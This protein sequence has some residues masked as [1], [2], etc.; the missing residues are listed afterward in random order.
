MKQKINFQKKNKKR[1]T[2]SEKLFLLAILLITSIIILNIST[3]ATQH[4][5]TSKSTTQ[6]STF[7]SQIQKITQ[8][9]SLNTNL[10]TGAFIGTQD[11]G[12]QSIGPTDDLNSFLDTFT[13]GI[14]TSFYGNVTSV[15][16]ISYNN[17]NILVNGSVTTFASAEIV[18]YQ[19][20]SL[21]TFNASVTINLSNT[22]PSM[23]GNAIAQASLLTLNNS[24]T[25]QGTSEC[26]VAVNT[27]GIYTLVAKASFNS[28]NST[29]LT[30]SGT[31]TGFGTL[32][33][34]F[35]NSTNQI[36]CSFGGS[37][38]V[39]A[40]TQIGEE[41]GIGLSGTLGSEALSPPTG[42]INLTFDNFNY[43]RTLNEPLCGTYSTSVTLKNHVSASGTCFT[44]TSSNLFLDCKGF[45][46]TFGNATG[47]AYGVNLDTNS[48]RIN[49]T[50]KNC[51]IND[52]VGGTGDIGIRYYQSHDNG[53]IWNNTI[54]SPSD[55]AAITIYYSNNTN[56][57]NNIITT[58][59]SSTGLDIEYSQ[60]TII[61]NNFINTSTSSNGIFILTGNATIDGNTINTSGSGEAISLS[62]TLN[63]TI[64]QNNIIHTLGNGGDGIDLATSIS[65]L[66]QTNMVTCG[67]GPVSTCLS[68]SSSNSSI[69]RDNN[70]TY[71]GSAGVGVGISV[72]SEKNYFI[73]N[74]ITS[75]SLGEISD[76][77]AS[78]YLNYV[79]YNNSF[80]EIKWLDN[81]TGS[82]PRNL[83]MSLNRT[84]GFGSNIFI[85]NNTIA[86]NKSAWAFGAIS[87]LANLTLYGINLSSVNSINKVENFTTDAVQ[88]QAAGPNCINLGCNNI[89]YIGNTLKFNTSNF[90]SFAANYSTFGGA[91]SS[92]G[93]LSTT[94]T[95]VSSV[96]STSTCF[97]I[98]ASNIILDCSG[99]TITYSTAGTLGYGINNSGY[100]NITIQNCRI[101]EGNIST[102]S[103]YGIYFQKNTT[104]DSVPQ[105]GTI[106]N[107]TLITSGASSNAIELDD[108]N[109]TNVS[110]NLINTTG[111]SAHG[112]FN[113]RGSNVSIMYNKIIVFNSSADNI[114]LATSPNSFLSSNNLTSYGTSSSTIDVREASGTTFTS[115]NLT[116]FGETATVFNFNS[117]FVSNNVTIISNE[118]RGNGSVTYLLLLQ[119]VNNSLV[120]NNQLSESTSGIGIYFDTST[121]NTLVNNNISVP[122]GIGGTW[123]IRDD[124]ANDGFFNYLI[125][126][127]SFGEIKWIDNGTGSFG[128]NLDVQIDR[129]ISSTS[130]I[131]IGNNTIAVNASAFQIG[132]INSTANLTLFSVGLSSIGQIQKVVNFTT[133]STEI[134]SAGINCTPS[135]GCSIISYTGGTLKFNTSSFSSFAGNLTAV[136][137]IPPLFNPLPTNQTSEFGDFFSYDF[138]ATDDVAISTYGIN[139][140]SLF[141]INSTGGLV[142]ISALSTP[143]NYQFNI[144][145][146]DTSNN[147][148]NTFFKIT[149]QDTIAPSFIPLIANQTLEVGNSFSYDINATDAL[150][151]NYSTNY[152][153]LFIF[154]STGGLTNT[155]SITTLGRFIFNI[156]I[157]DTS[158]NRNG[159]FFMITMQDTIAP[160]FIPLVT[161]QTIEYATQFTYDINATDILFANY[162]INDTQFSINNTGGIVNTTHLSIGGYILNISIND[163][164]N[165]R[166]STFFKITIQ[167]TTIP[168]ISNISNLTFDNT[169]NLIA[170]YNASD[171]VNISTW[172]TNDTSHFTINTT[173]YF[174]NTTILTLATYWINISVNDTSNNK[175]GLIIFVNVTA[176]VISS[177]N[178]G[179]GN[180][181]NN[182][183][184]SSSSSSETSTTTSPSAPATNPTQTA[185][186]PQSETPQ[187]T[188]SLSIDTGSSSGKSSEN[189][190]ESATSKT[191]QLTGV[192]AAENTQNNQNSPFATGFALFQNATSIAT[193]YS[194][195]SLSLFAFIFLLS[196][197]VYTF[198]TIRKIPFR[199]VPTMIEKPLPKTFIEKPTQKILT[200][201]T[202]QP[203]PY[204]TELQSI[205]QEI[206][207]YGIQIKPTSPPH[208]HKTFLDRFKPSTY[209]TYKS[210]I[211]ETPA[212]KS[213][214]DKQLQKLE[215]EIANLERPIPTTNLKT[216]PTS[217]LK[218]QSTRELLER[219]N[220]TF[221]QA[222]TTPTQNS[223]ITN[224]KNKSNRYSERYHKELEKIEQEIT[225]LRQT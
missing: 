125:Y 141:S 99:Y 50:V 105:K 70:I 62:S 130:N 39:N 151:A 185:D 133:N 164:S 22:S 162:S 161:N 119:R 148:N 188:T 64:I 24:N 59:A 210:V 124:N 54:I 32:S 110:S 144:S 213:H 17:N 146:N 163:T 170:Q 14:N 55:V 15:I 57:T 81:G 127:N 166:N 155:S 175:A 181:N 83:T 126:N 49:V 203:S 202:S 78:V 85:G 1:S 192:T 205:S 168:T 132:K 138:N 51:N 102:N 147:R 195:F 19:N 89:S 121:G 36:T 96:S 221:N 143:G 137:S 13:G 41:F 209:S 48:P 149:I 117:A 215:Q 112:M 165:N 187:P 129:D 156:S 44:F 6:Q 216:T 154:N 77:T 177:S 150:F 40:I 88:I 122:D 139:Y 29:I 76:T 106:F 65:T 174:K 73:N 84:L 196:I 34:H 9:I 108:A 82:L 90:S 5:S 198:K 61:E 3:N 47:S 10:L 123:E 200:K 20:L 8:H 197:T 104:G 111:S 74:N 58:N 33:M 134:R 37:T 87:S 92:C 11:L 114:I 68:L 21:N 103:K 79:V 45:N 224:Q 225:K 184:G 173:G 204:E 71:T 186:K 100:S 12:I 113:T 211:M 63:G 191:T 214:Y 118:I 94:T 142:N 152:T 167:D 23:T 171:N 207:G 38:V 157:N 25:S 91:T 69:I 178:S 60:N 159:T 28:K 135:G 180:S 153:S 136:D 109:L 206:Q 18:T 158:N 7:L 194:T 176:N 80:G 219:K 101:V 140:T 145:I 30:G 27:T 193:K 223:K 160:S 218:C 222:T 220:N 179:S 2:L 97:H 183:G 72:N 26:Y 46:I 182:G 53:T 56:I 199:K 52:I 67:G 43:T 93:L 169:Y 35:D 201:S 31:N 66:I 217:Q 107:N 98:N 190:Q 212:S 4:T 189:N 16:N 75:T 116:N 120:N 95:L 131:F 86:L 172:F 42:G 128:R 115:N 208:S